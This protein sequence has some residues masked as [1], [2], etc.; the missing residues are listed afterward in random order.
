MATTS[1]VANILGKFQQERGEEIAMDKLLKKQLKEKQKQIHR[2][3]GVSREV[4]ALMTNEE[5]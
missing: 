5:I 3:Q 2:P 4:F 1:D